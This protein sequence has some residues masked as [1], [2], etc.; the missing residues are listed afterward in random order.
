MFGSYRRGRT[1]VHIGEDSA[2]FG[3][4]KL[5]FAVAFLITIPAL[6]YLNEKLFRRVSES[7]HK[8]AL[9]VTSFNA[10]SQAG[11]IVHL[12]GINYTSTVE[13]SDFKVNM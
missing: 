12:E 3:V 2:V 4:L 9:N 5:V 1:H 11:D 10:G 7:V 6:A 8:I 13:D